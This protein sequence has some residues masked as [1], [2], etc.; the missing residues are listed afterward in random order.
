M[1]RPRRAVTRIAAVVSAIVMSSAIALAPVAAHADVEPRTVHVSG[2][3]TLPE[4]VVWTGGYIDVTV[5]TYGFT[6]GQQT[7]YSPDQSFDFELDPDRYQIW[8]DYSG[9]ADLV[10]DLPRDLDLRS[11][12]TEEV[13]LSVVPSASPSGRIVA[14]ELPPASMAGVAYD[15][16]TQQNRGVF[17]Y[18]PETGDY[19]LSGLAPDE[20]S[21]QVRPFD[22]DWQS[23]WWPSVSAESA[24]EGI[25]LQAGENRTGVDF[26]L[27]AVTR[28]SGTVVTRSATGQPVPAAHVIVDIDTEIIGSEGRYAVETDEQGHYEARIPAGSYHTAYRSS[29]VGPGAEGSWVRAPGP[30]FTLLDGQVLAGV[31]GEVERGGVIT[32]TVSSKA[33]DGAWFATVP[34]R[35][36]EAT[37]TW[38]DYRGADSDSGYSID[39]LPAGD[40]RV[41]F[42]ES[43]NPSATALRAEY[44]DDTP[45]ASEATLVHV[46]AGEVTSGIDAQLEAVSF[47]VFRVS[48]PD[49]YSVAARLSSL[50]FE[51]GPA[52]VYVASGEN[53]PDALSAGPAAA[54]DGTGLLLVGRDVLPDS[55]RAELERLRPDRIV[56][57]GGPA[58]VG[59][60]VYARLAKIA[61]TSRIGGADRYEV[62]RKIVEQAFCSQATGTCEAQT[63]YFATGENFPDALTAGPAA[64][65]K[66]GA[67]LLVPG[68]SDSVDAETAALVGELG[69]EQGYI[70]GGPNS[71]G[72]SYRSSL[73]RLVPTVTRIGGADRFEVGAAVAKTAF[74]SSETVFVASG[75]V[76][77]DALSAGPV[78]AALD[79]PTLLVRH[80]CVPVKAAETIVDLNPIDIVVVGGPVTVEPQVERFE[81]FC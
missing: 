43:Y 27:R 75:E 66:E 9:E 10:R 31:D 25:V 42:S 1:A 39:G 4:G 17:R 67:I 78:A 61:P 5:G 70:A 28:V 57:V 29:P 74:D 64:A 15:R 60:A 21:V 23:T 22:P 24:A 18:D 68:R 11:A 76:F 53:Y 33:V 55:T 79:A 13:T 6:T 3:V 51:P 35:W 26:S 20:N 71:V 19:T 2:T 63:V 48:G 45:Y 30:D 12:T 44:Y 72:E 49:R 36:D 52:V 65:E 77:P 38:V 59:P 47:G 32:G 7:L 34:S 80:D 50:T 54:R 16:E 69:V 40:Y 14:G 41:R 8:A 37:G 56:V 46:T 62:S 58:S 81:A 73:N